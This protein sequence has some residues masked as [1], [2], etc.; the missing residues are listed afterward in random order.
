MVVPN[1]AV[2]PPDYRETTVVIQ[3]VTVPAYQYFGKD[4]EIVNLGDT[5]MPEGSTGSDFYLLYGMDPEG[6]AGWYQ[7]DRTQ[8]TYQ[9][10]NT[11]TASDEDE[12]A[13]YETLLKSYNELDARFKD[14]KTKDRRVI[15]VLI[16]VTVVLLIV[17]LNIILHNRERFDEDEEEYVPRKA[18]P[19]REKPAREKPVKEK[20]D[21]AYARMEEEDDA[22]SFYAGDT[23]E[24]MTE[25]EDE[26]SILSRH[27]GQKKREPKRVEQPPKRDTRRPEPP[28]PK[29]EDDDIEFL[30]L[31]DL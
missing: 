30:D 10:L 15:A 28:M 16:F 9:R 18:K 29:E 7:F 4:V 31:N 22:S 20:P 24:I 14:T 8:G 11:D 12:A 27:T 5:E 21:R 23:Q 1:G 2:P 25:F 17:I 13:N 19:A 6:V 3:D 26:P